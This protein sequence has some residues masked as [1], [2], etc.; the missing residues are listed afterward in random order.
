MSGGSENITLEDRLSNVLFIKYLSFSTTLNSFFFQYMVIEGL[1][2]VLVF[3]DQL[4]N[5]YLPYEWLIR[6]QFQQ[7]LTGNFTTQITAL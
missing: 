2:S 5:P 1:L 7:F 6:Y 4:L 3:W